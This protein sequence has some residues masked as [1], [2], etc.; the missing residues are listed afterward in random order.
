MERLG[1][2][3]EPDAP[4]PGQ[5]GINGDGQL[6]MRRLHL[7]FAVVA[8]QPLSTWELESELEPDEIDAIMD[9]IEQRMAARP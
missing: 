8:G 4:F 2:Q 9:F 6:V 1:V 5:G 3:H 7:L